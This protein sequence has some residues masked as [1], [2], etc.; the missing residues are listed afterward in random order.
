LA[1]ALAPNG[2]LVLANGDAVNP[3]PGQPREIVEF[4]TLGEFVSQLSV[5]KVQGSAFGLAIAATAPTPCRSGRCA[6]GSQITGTRSP[7]PAHLLVQLQH[8]RIDCFEGFGGEIASV[9]A[10]LPATIVE[11]AGDANWWPRSR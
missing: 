6:S 9:S 10:L 3:N 7:T 8:L 1:L 11:L 2:Q 4:T 5:D